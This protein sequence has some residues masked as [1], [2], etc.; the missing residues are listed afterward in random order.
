MYTQYAAAEG[1]HAYAQ[2][3]SAGGHVQYAA[4]GEHAYAQDGSAGGHAQYAAAED[5]NLGFNSLLS[6]FDE[7]F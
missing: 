4:E 5:N 3:G 7:N 2:D 6:Y 1:E